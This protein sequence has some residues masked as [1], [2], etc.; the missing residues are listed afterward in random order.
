[1]TVDGLYWEDAGLADVGMINPGD[2]A[3]FV[4][5][6]GG[7]RP[8]VLR[9]VCVDPP[10]RFVDF[11]DGMDRLCMATAVDP[12]VLRRF[13]IV[14]P[15]FASRRMAELYAEEQAAARESKKE[16]GR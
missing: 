14:A 13:E 7:G 10:V 12:A 6:D 4:R 5:C 2:A 3:Y 8:A 15:V 1:M 11:G 9:G 16:G